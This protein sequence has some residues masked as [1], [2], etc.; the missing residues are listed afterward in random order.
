[1]SN[2]G[3]I[4]FLRGLKTKSQY[5]LILPSKVHNCKTCSVIAF[6]SSGQTKLRMVIILTLLFITIF[7]LGPARDRDHVLAR[8]LAHVPA[9]PRAAVLAAEAATLGISIATSGSP[10][11]KTAVEADR[12]LLD[13]V[14]DRAAD[15][16]WV[17]MYINTTVTYDLMNKRGVASIILSLVSLSDGYGRSMFDGFHR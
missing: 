2:F 16:R 11:P 12:S 17:C 1:M 13:R 8:D 5:Y 4:L 15:K 6:R 14:P 10:V 3:T 7:T 9:R